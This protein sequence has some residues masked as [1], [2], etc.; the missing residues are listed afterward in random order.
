MVSTGNSDLMLLG[1]HL[2]L[3][4]CLAAPGHQ[5]ISVLYCLPFLVFTDSELVVFED[6]VMTVVV[7]MFP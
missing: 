1:S 2:L 5:C 4:D 7:E 3:E 6:S